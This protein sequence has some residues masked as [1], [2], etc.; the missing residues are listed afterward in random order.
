METTAKCAYC[1]AATQLFNA[2][3]PI[4]TE[5]D[6]AHE[7]ENPAKWILEPMQKQTTEEASEV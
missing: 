1:G 4:C 7:K 2:G 5:C 3:I 6:A